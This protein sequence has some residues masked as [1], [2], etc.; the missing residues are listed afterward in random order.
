V[1]APRSNDTEEFHLR[2]PPM[3]QWP[4]QRYVV[5]VE[6]PGD[7]AEVDHRSSGITARVVGRV[8]AVYQASA[9]DPIPPRMERALHSALGCCHP[10]TGDCDGLA[11]ARVWKDSRSGDEREGAK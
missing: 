10:A 7:V 1:T 11:V 2:L 4:G 9:P 5:D 6:S 8:V 3:P